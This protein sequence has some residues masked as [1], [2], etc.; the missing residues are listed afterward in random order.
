MKKFKVRKINKK[1]RIL[2]LG[3]IVLIIFI[4]ISFC[5]LSKSHSNLVKELLNDFNKKDS[6]IFNKLTNNLDNLL[7]TSS[8]K[9]NDSNSIPF[10]IE[11]KSTEEIDNST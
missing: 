1:Y 10:I 9:N 8:F 11:E 5:K 7:K 2:I 4:I 6:L 3:L